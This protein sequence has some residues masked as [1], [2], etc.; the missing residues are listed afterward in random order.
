MLLRIPILLSL[1]LSACGQ[2]VRDLRLN[3]VDLS[4]KAAIEQIGHELSDDDRIAFTTYVLVHGP[5]GRLCG[6][7][8]G[9]NSKQPETIGEAIDFTRFGA[10]GN[11]AG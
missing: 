3:E 5:S 1:F 4:N 6:T 9:R 10:A 7:M 8:L 11:G 2:N